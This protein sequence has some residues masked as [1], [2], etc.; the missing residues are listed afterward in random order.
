MN[1]SISDEIYNKLHHAKTIASVNPDKSLE[2]SEEAYA[3]AK[4]NNL[5]V[6]SEYHENQGDYMNALKYY[7]NYYNFKEQVMN[8]NLGNKLEILNIELK[9]IE[10]IGEFEQIKI[11]LEK[12]IAI[13]KNELEKI[14][15]ENKM[16]E[17]EAYEDELTGIPNRR[18]INAYL[19]KF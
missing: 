17:K 14:K 4:A 6:E 18:S 8:S 2:I 19:K 9:N 5:E 3:L 13:Q 16:L 11:R 1:K 10:I 15:L 12:K 7:K